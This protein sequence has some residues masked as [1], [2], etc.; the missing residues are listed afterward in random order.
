MPKVICKNCAKDFNKS[1]SQIKRTKNNFCSQSCAAT[2]NNHTKA[3]KQLHKQCKTCDTFIYKHRTYCD[4]CH[5]S[6]KT[7]SK[8]SKVCP[9]CNQNKPITDFHKRG[10]DSHLYQYQCKNCRNISC[11]KKY[12][13]IK[14]KCI[15][16]KGGKCEKCGY[17]KCQAA[18][19]FHHIDPTEK[20]FQISQFQFFDWGKN[21][22][23]I[24]N[25]LDKCML[26]C[27]NCHREIHYQ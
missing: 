18:L 2:Y 1:P 11:K 8:K 6:Y 27:A 20:N 22:Y 5:Q 19:D 21:K 26:I 10:N 14:Q 4:S 17:N 16:Y 9:T 15:D 23:K 24:I 7:Q 12:R 13:N 25:E 3:K